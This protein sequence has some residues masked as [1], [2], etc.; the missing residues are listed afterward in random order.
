MRILHVLAASVSCLLAACGPNARL[1][2][3]GQLVLTGQPT[4][5]AAGGSAQ[6]TATLVQSSGQSDVTAAAVWS[7]S[8][9]SIA[10]VATG[11]VTGVAAGDVVITAAYANTS[12]HFALTILPAN[13]TVP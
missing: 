7:S 10:G 4:Q 3:G 12:A 8:N 5:L 9:A 11:L 2:Q 6:V 1:L 13:V